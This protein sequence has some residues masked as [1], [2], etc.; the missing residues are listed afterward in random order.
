MIYMATEQS[1]QI[2]DPVFYTGEKFRKL[3]GKKGWIH[4]R[5]VNQENTYVVV[6]PDT[7]NRK[8]DQ[9]DTDDYVMSG[10]VLSKWRPPPGEKKPEGP[11]VQ[12]R[13]R[14]QQEEE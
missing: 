13:R 12:T 2:D 4:A 14:R 10:K 3:Q 5:V 8:E 7:A 1:Y 11:E 9:T 6:F